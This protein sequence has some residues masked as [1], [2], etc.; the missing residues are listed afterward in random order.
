MLISDLSEQFASIA[1]N[2]ASNSQYLLSDTLKSAFAIFSLKSPSLLNFQERTRMEDGNLQCIYGI[3]N[4]PSDTQMRTILDE[5]PADSLRYSF[6]EVFTHLESVK[7]LDSYGYQAAD[8]ALII[9]TDGVEHFSLTKVHCSCCTVKKHQDGNTSC[10]HTAL[11]A[12]I[13]HPDKAQVFPLAV[14]PIARA[15][16]FGGERL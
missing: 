5:V 7:V 2:R 8:N 14:E 11:A 10:H 12:V 4:I 6:A 9:S 13:V 16:R 15:G 1:D 3:K